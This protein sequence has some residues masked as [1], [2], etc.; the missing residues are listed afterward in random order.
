MRAFFQWIAQAV[1]YFLQWRANAT[2]PAAKKQKAHEKWQIELERLQHEADQAQ[3]DYE[4]FV[5]QAHSGNDTHGRG[6]LLHAIAKE[7]AD[8]VAAH[9]HREP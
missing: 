6:M 1:M 8:A 4:A 2:D 5:L 9:R 3:A 7:A